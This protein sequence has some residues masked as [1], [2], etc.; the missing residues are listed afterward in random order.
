VVASV[1]D[2][3]IK[4]M[5]IKV[6]AFRTTKMKDNHF[7]AMSLT[8]DDRTV[9]FRDETLRPTWAGGGGGAWLASDSFSV[10]AR[11]RPRG[12]WG[13]GRGFGRAS[14]GWGDGFGRR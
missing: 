14:R 3:L 7:V 8:Y 6:E 10:G 13:R 9:R 12:G 5:A 4:E 11:S 2:N 1:A